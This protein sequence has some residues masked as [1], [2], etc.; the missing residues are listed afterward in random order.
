MIRHKH[1]GAKRTR[2]IF[3]VLALV[4]LSLI[5]MMFYAAHQRQLRDQAMAVAQ[6][7]Q[8][9]RA[10]AKAKALE[11]ARRELPPD[12]G[13][14][15]DWQFGEATANLPHDQIITAYANAYLTF[16]RGNVDRDFQVAQNKVENAIDAG[17]QDPLLQ[18]ID[19][20]QHNRDEILASLGAYLETAPGIVAFE[21]ALRFG[22]VAPDANNSWHLRRFSE[23]L[24]LRAL[25]EARQGNADAAVQSLLNAVTTARILEEAQEYYR[26]FGYARCQIA[27]VKIIDAAWRTA[28]LSPEHRQRLVDAFVCDNTV[29]RI[30]ECMHADL[31][32]FY[33]GPPNLRRPDDDTPA[34]LRAGQMFFEKTVG[35]AALPRTIQQLE[36]LLRA[37]PHTVA[38]QLFALWKGIPRFAYRTEGY[39]GE[40]LRNYAAGWRSTITP[41]IIRLAFALKDYKREHGQYPDSLAGLGPGFP[42]SPVDPV[43][44]APMVYSRKEAGFVITFP[45]APN[46]KEFKSRIPEPTMWEFEE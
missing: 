28:P 16:S 42:P 14:P 11:K 38:P 43:S 13:V 21:N 15:A 41:G 8:A 26:S 33:E 3:G 5:G 25:A 31:R 2:W 4:L 18:Q 39:I 45:D 22:L 9:E 35:C 19:Q 32:S 7:E 24:A 6:R 37:Q 36:T 12:A 23:A 29:D 44:G 46:F 17:Q 20:R 34:L 30:A 40:M 1:R 27:L 10:E